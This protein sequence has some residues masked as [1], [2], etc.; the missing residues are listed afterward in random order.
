MWK[1]ISNFIPTDIDINVYGG[2]KVEEFDNS[3]NNNVFVYLAKIDDVSLSS[4]S[5]EVSRETNESKVAT[6]KNAG[7]QLLKYALKDRWGIN[8]DLSSI[9]LS[10]NGKPYAEGYQFSI[11]HCGSLVCVAISKN[12]QVGVDLECVTTRRNWQGLSRRVLTAEERD[13]TNI[14]S[15]TMTSI[16]TKKE[17]VFKLLGDK[18]FSP[19]NI[20]YNQYCTDTIENITLVYN[21]YTLTLATKEITNNYLIIRKAFLNDNKWQLK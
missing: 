9:K 20:D 4:A 7:L 12:I 17:A 10:D 5:T 2:E 6:Q 3:C 14:D 8:E 13:N 11:S 19:S 21:D 15:Q 1:V 16:W 18:V